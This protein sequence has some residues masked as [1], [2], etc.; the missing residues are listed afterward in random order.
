MPHDNFLSRFRI[1]GTHSYV[2]FFSSNFS[3]YSDPFGG[4]PLQIF[5]DT[6]EIPSALFQQN[7][8]NNSADLCDNNFGLLVLF[9]RCTIIPVCLCLDC[10]GIYNLFC[11]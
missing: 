2:A 6:S 11:S 5:R 1:H 4:M 3:R 10:G 7:K 9:N 8:H